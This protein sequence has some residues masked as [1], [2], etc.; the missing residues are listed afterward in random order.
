VGANGSLWEL[1]EA[2]GANGSYCDYMGAKG[3]KWELIKANL[4]LWELKQENES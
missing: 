1:M 4:K 3:N 2:N